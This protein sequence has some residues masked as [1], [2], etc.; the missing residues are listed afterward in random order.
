MDGILYI[1]YH[2]YMALK[3]PFTQNCTGYQ[4]NISNSFYFHYFQ[5]N[6]KII[7]VCDCITGPLAPGPVTSDI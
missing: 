5:N 3:L 7:A 2:R 4:G 6:T 1:I